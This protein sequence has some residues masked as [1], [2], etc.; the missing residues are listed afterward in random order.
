[1]EVVQDMQPLDVIVAWP[2]PPPGPPME[3]RVAEDTH[4]PPDGLVGNQPVLV[5]RS[6]RPVRVT[7]GGSL[8]VVD[9]PGPGSGFLVGD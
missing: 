2:A 5:G 7:A 6:G 9:G 4:V 3:V 8:V 1:M